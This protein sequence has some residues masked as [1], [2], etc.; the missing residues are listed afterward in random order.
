MR[1]AKRRVQLFCDFERSHQ[2]SRFSSS[3][4]ELPRACG[5]SR[6]N[7]D[8]QCFSAIASGFCINDITSASTS[9]IP[10]RTPPRGGAIRVLFVYNMKRGGR[11]KM[12]E[13]TETTF[14]QWFFGK[15]MSEKWERRDR[16]LWERRDRALWVRSTGST[17]HCEDAR[18]RCRR[19]Q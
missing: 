8:N 16:A 10:F 7:A 6:S 13:A 9:I 14:F 19:T 15:E 11:A 18:T 5:R 1:I 2:K 12:T 17:I 4:Q 3:C